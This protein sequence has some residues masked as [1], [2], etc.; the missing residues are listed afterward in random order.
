MAPGYS[1]III[2]D[3]VLPD[4]GTPLMQAS[5]DIQM[6]SIGAGVERSESQWRE[7]LDSAGLEITGIWSTGPGMEAIIEAI[8][9]HSEV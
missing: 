4:V 1:K 2:I 8:P 5:M 7:L 3:F 9:A 6:M